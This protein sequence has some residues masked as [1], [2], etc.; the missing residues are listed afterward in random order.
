MNPGDRV[1]IWCDFDARGDEGSRRQ[2][3]VWAEN[4]TDGAE[5]QKRFV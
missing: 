2:E 3:R 5:R 1:E 4:D